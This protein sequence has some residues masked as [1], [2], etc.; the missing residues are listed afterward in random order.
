MCTSFEQLG[1]LQSNLYEML[2]GIDCPRCMSLIS[3]QC[4]LLAVR[5]WHL[6]FSRFVWPFK[7]LGKRR[8]SSF[9]VSMNAALLMLILDGSMSFYRM[10]KYRSS[11]FRDNRVLVE[12]RLISWPT[13]IV[14]VRCRIEESNAIPPETPCQY[15]YTFFQ[16]DLHHVR[17]V[18]VG[19]RQGGGVEPSYPRCLL[20]LWHPCFG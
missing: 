15:M 17:V 16:Y 13:T 7:H 1:K 20:L 14:D 10:W 9:L 6:I 3:L 8:T 19:C 12:I 11:L 18:L 4:V 5:P 2:S